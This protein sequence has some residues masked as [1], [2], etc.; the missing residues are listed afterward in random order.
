M[1][2]FLISVLK[3]YYRNWGVI[4]KKIKE[5]W[6]KV[7]LYIVS[8]WLLFFL[9]IIITIDIPIYFGE[10]FRFIGFKELIKR[11]IVPL[12]SFFFL[13]MGLV[14]V[15][16][17]KY[18]MAGSKKTP[19]QITKIKNI[20]FEHLTFLTTY[21]IPLICFNFNS[22]RYLIVLFLLLI[23]IGMMY[24]KTNMFYANPSLALLGYHIYEI[25]A[26]FRTSKR[27]NII[28]ITRQKLDIGEKVS[29]RK[30]DKKIY[31]G[32]KK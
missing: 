1:K 13:I 15:N 27:K 18:K 20:N 32:R 19:F 12:I 10:E 8:L 4:I 31:Y 23:I 2:W 28:V 6:D 16:R 14:F 3:N 26:E 5:I 7:E 9:I 22:L 30:L 21:I 24:I 11:N 29:Y 25:D 17:F